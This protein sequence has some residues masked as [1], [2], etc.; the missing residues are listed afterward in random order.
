MIDRLRR[1]EAEDPATERSLSFS[2]ADA[3]RSGR[4]VM[5]LEDGRVTI[6]DRTLIEGGDMWLE[7]GEHVTLI[8]ANGTGKTTLVE[9]LVGRRE[10]QGGR[11]KIGHKVDLGYLSQ[12]AD[13]PP[14]RDLTVLAHAQRRTGLSEAKTRALLG[15]FLFSGD[16]VAKAVTSISGGEAQRLALAILVNSGANVLVLDEPTNHLDVESREALEDALRAFDGTLLLI[17]H[18]RAL[19]EAVGS[20]TI[21]LADRR[22][23]SH[24]GG[25]ASYRAEEEEARREGE[26][27]K[28]AAPQARPARAK[29]PSKN[30]IADAERLEREAVAAERRLRELEE[31]LSDPSRWGDPRTSAKSTRRHEAAKRELDEAIAA[32]ERAAELAG[33]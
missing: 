31:E 24:P 15:R 16:E 13:A 7:R 11:L 26:R 8:G 27:A 30:R 4:V 5:E 29:A 20:R 32:W 18:D 22:L 9:S 3:E 6:G 21:V 25:W 2:F 33:Q 17:S 12:H 1:E 19:L 10:L 28:R 14:E 23:R